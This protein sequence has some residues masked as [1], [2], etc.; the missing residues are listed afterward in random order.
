MF[1]YYQPNK[2]DIKDEYGDC[3][4]RALSRVLDLSWL[5]TFDLIVPIE[6]K[7][8]VANIFGAPLKV[9]KEMLAELGLN[10]H[11]ISNQKK[12]PTVKSFA[13]SHKEGRFILNVA[14]HEV[15]CV[16]G[17]YYDTWNS[18]YKSLYGYFSKE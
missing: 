9:R 1:K 4:I 7:Y 2:K 17:I 18:G 15:A 5:E 16:D 10:Y 12:R 6:R 3:T 13:E 11:P 8:Q 14:H